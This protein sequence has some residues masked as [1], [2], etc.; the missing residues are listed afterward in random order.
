MTVKQFE[1][2]K[3]GDV[4]QWNDGTRSVVVAPKICR[5]ID[6]EKIAEWLRLQHIGGGCMETLHRY[7]NTGINWKTAK[8]V[9]TTPQPEDQTISRLGMVTKPHIFTLPCE[10]VF[11]PGNGTRFD[12]VMSNL[13]SGLLLV[14]IPNF[15]SGYWFSHQVSPGYVEEKLRLLPG[16]ATHIADLINAQLGCPSHFATHPCEICGAQTPVD[17]ELCGPCAR[18]AH[19]VSCFGAPAKPESTVHGKIHPAQPA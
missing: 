16:D 4:V 2:L 13:M 10:F 5:K 17:S 3:P 8:L 11:E 19:E 18:E 7:E 12:I 14:A 6:G 1:T 9:K 15:R